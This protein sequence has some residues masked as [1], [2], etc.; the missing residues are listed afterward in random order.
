MEQCC[1]DV[2]DSGKKGKKQGEERILA[3]FGEEDFIAE[4]NRCVVRILG[5]KKTEGA[6][7]RMIRFFGLF[8][9][10]SAE[11]DAALFSPEE[12]ED[13]VAQA[14]PETPSTRLTFSVLSMLIPLLSAKEK[15]VRYRATQIISH[16]INT[17]ESIDDE[18]Y[19]LIRQS[20]MKRIR[21][22]EPTIR[23]QAVMGLG[24]LAG[25]EA[26]EDEDDEDGEDVDSSGLLG[27]L[28]DALQ[29]DT[30]AEVRRSLLLNLPLTPS[31]LPYLLERAR[32]LD[33]PTRRALYARLLPTL[34][35]FRHL[36]LSMREKLLR[37]GL[38]DRDENVR[39]A[40][41]RLFRERWIEDC[42]GT[43]VE[44]EEGQPITQQEAAP[45]SFSAL[46][47][48]LERIDVVNSGVED[49]IALEA[50]KDF[51]DGRPDYL[52]A[53]IFDDEFW[54]SLTPEAAFV[55]RSF[56]DFCQQD[57]KYQSLVEE[58]MPEVT[59]L[60]FYLQKYLNT[61][62]DTLKKAAEEGIEEDTVEQEFIVEQLLHMALT[63]DYTDEIGRRKMF[64]LLR[65]A[66]AMA[67][68]PDEV[69][70]LAIEVLRLV[71]G[72]DAAGEK[73]FCG[74]VLEAIA[75][76]HDNIAPEPVEGE[77]DDSF[78]S[79]KSEVS[80]DRSPNLSR[81]STSRSGISG[82]DRSPEQEEKAIKE[83]MINMKCL[84]IAQCM[85]QNVD[86]NLQQNISLV[87]MLNN[88]VVPAVRSHEA[89]IRERGLFCL[90]LCSLLDRTLAEE[91]I[92]LFIHCF[93]KGHEALQVTSLQI[94]CDILVTH[95]TLLSPTESQDEGDNP[96]TSV[97]AHQKPLLKA[98]TR[99]LKPTNSAPAVQA[100]AAT[101]L[102]K[103]LLTSRLLVPCASLDDLLRTLVVA[104]FNP[105]TADNPA[106]RQSLAYF[107]PA[108]A[109]SRLENCERMNR[110]AVGVVHQVMVAADEYYTLEAEEDSDG[111]VDETQAEKQVKALMGT[112]V[113]ILSEWTDGRKVVSIGADRVEAA[114]EKSSTNSKG[115][116]LQLGVAID[117]LE[118][119]LSNSCHSQEKKYLLNFLG[120]LSVHSPVSSASTTTPP[121]SS[122]GMLS[123]EEQEHNSQMEMRDKQLQLA[124][125]LKDL[126]D[127]AIS[128]D[129][130]KD[131]AGRNTL[132]KVKNSVLKL[133]KPP[134]S[135]VAKGR[136]S[137]AVSRMSLA[138][139]SGL[140]IDNRRASGEEGLDE[141]GE[142]D[143][144]PLAES[145]TEVVEQMQDLEEEGQEHDL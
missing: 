124:S 138:P 61:L 6:G 114:S 12:N 50:M 79:A 71:C 80:D 118:R 52:D 20:L 3:Q 84:H 32:D 68:L 54:S 67:D 17:L 47:E 111:D 89:P 10:T 23:I 42:A 143:E 97:P 62:L 43:R 112:V 105:A 94:L 134:E 130:A 70:R 9:K 15:T 4:S 49:G 129:L 41:G 14:V 132:V 125:A 98:F 126:L 133:I 131:A 39:K 76:V 55:A 127:E 107:L 56:N 145:P 88:L 5:V 103:M 120:K 29:N 115:E 113:G 7:D 110:V 11:R 119:A 117:I 31:T 90:G 101:S 33:G 64:S 108:Y 141:K 25:N 2:T 85:L 104:F 19:H 48:L 109:L 66:L 135:A 40:A 100:A 122:H 82:E 38:R 87:T 99:A 44:T 136:Q 26:E 16:V 45:P 8:L 106:L 13:D 92:T 24:R 123:L 21:D 18:L 22:K 1:Y 121:S 59:R 74:V 36:S 86:G 46:L 75:E 140:T 58:K 72:N 28:L 65:E 53:V 91:N 144:A 57:D 34:G 37:W 27:K 30:S 128:E 69:T 139:S 116:N 96:A 81:K 137:L 102:S 83:I 60:G 73:E 35:D 78:V 51:W 95:P 77:E 63:L 93:S 142:E